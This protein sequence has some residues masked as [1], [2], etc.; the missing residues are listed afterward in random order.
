VTPAHEMTLSLGGLRI[1]APQAMGTIRLVPIL[2][3]DP[4]GDLRVHAR[5]YPSAVG[6]VGLDAQPEASKHVYVSYIPH[7]FVFSYTDNRTEAAQGASLGSERPRWV[8][9]HHRIVKREDGDGATRRFRMLPLHLAM[10]G[11]LALHFSG[12]DVLWREFSQRSSSRGLDPRVE[13]SYGGEVIRGFDTAVRVFEIHPKQVGLM[14][15]VAET[16]ASAFVVSHPDDYR[17]MHRSLLEDFFGELLYT[18]AILFA[19]TLPLSAPIDLSAAKTIDDLAA[20][21]VQARHTW[22]DH[23]EQ[24]AGGL[25]GRSFVV[26]PIRRAGPFVLERFLPVFDPKRECHI[27]E[28]IVRSDGTLEYLKTFRLSQAQIRRAY[29]LQ[30]LAAAQWNLDRAAETLGSPRDELVRRLINAGLG[31]LL[32]RHVTDPILGRP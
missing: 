19:D 13:R 2:R 26:E 14:V 20:A 10:E 12:P 1:G 25:I 9:L 4:P 28:R 21:V 30:T 16:L 5:G 32:A 15:F 24:L 11:F 22:S 29:L 3:D 7:G 27:G 17:R 23:A 6:V 8:R 18:S 31:D